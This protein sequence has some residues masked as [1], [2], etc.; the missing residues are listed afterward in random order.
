M[1]I[2]KV[3][4]LK[5]T[6]MSLENIIQLK[7]VQLENMQRDNGRLS[8]ELKKQQRYVRNL[9]RKTLETWFEFIAILKCIDLI[10]EQLDDE[11]FLYQREKDF[12]DSEMQR[13]KVRYGASKLSQRRKE[14]EVVRECLEDENKSLR[15]E[16][17]E[18]VE[19][20][21]NL[22]I[23]FLRMKYAKDSLRE[24]FDQLLKEHLGVMSDMMEKLDEARE[25]LNIIVSEKFQDP[26]PLSK[27]KFLQ[28]SFIKMRLIL[29]IS[30]FYNV[31]FLIFFIFF[32]IKK[33]I[34][35]RVK[36]QVVQRNARLVHENAAL[37]MQIQQLTLNI[38]R[39][40]N[41]MQKT[42][43]V[44]VDA[45]I[46]AKLATQNKKRRSKEFTKWLPFQ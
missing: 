38:E 15:E 1:S 18:K 41:C 10:S 31:L 22:C 2:W 43:S 46:I 12:F 44:N 28:V 17:N 16:L 32:N 21:Y 33:I 23:K 19:T 14:L 13:Q 24:K 11:R 27:A 4:D 25:E 42:K 39:L 6:V 35:Y 8:V 37:K 29:T 34:V 5:E 40:N 26:L 3:A 9:K 20:T 36:S 45:K 7:D 30:R